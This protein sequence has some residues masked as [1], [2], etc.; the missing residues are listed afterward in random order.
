MTESF[1]REV[2][3]RFVPKEFGVSMSVLVVDDDPTLL[4]NIARSL[5]RNGFCVL[6]AVSGKEV[7]QA[8]SQG[9]I[10]AICLD[11][12]LPDC[13]G[14]DLLEELREARPELVAIIISGADT[15]EN[16]SRAKLLGA[17]A[18]L[19]K[20]FSLATLNQMLHESLPEGRA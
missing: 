18:F 20:P 6:T 10:D 2:R 8:V 11:I 12:S 16:R 1:G 19:P 4:K 13:N 5:R 3:K 15:A 14:L 9:A 17:K 7:E